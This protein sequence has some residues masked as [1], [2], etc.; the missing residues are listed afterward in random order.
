M[1]KT[2]Q[3]VLHH[4]ELPNLLV[5]LLLLLIFFLPFK[6][7]AETDA[8]SIDMANTDE[9]KVFHI[10]LMYLP[11]STLQSEIA[12]KLTRRFKHDQSNIHISTIADYGSSRAENTVPDLIVAIGLDNIQNAIAHYSQIDKLLIASDP[13][14][15]SQINNNGAENAVLYMTQ[16]YC[17][18]IQFIRLINDQWRKVSYFSDQNKPVDDQQLKQCALKYNL[19]TY[20]VNVS[21]TN[22]LTDHIK[23]ALRHSDLI[24]ALPDKDIYNSKTV[25]NILLTSYRYRKPVIAFSESFVNAGALASIHSNT[26]QISESAGDLVEQ[27]ITSDRKFI[28]T[29]N[30]PKS[31]EIDINSQVFRALDLNIPDIDRIM[32]VIDSTDLTTTR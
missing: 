2:E 17:R 1:R 29:V 20:R 19:D 24:L 23:N 30:Y 6:I 8:T 28:H 13:G 14:D 27:Y 22:R 10:A 21:D 3:G 15:Y 12:D 31:F 9:R 26:A 7:Y 4:G 32:Q 11:E 18:Q 25:K 16:P 5:H